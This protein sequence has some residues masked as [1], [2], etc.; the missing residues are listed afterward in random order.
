MNILRYIFQ[1]SLNVKKPLRTG[2]KMT[3]YQ[4]SFE[5]NIGLQSFVVNFVGANRQFAFLEISLVYDKSDQHKTTYDSYNT[6]VAVQKIKS[7]KIP[8]TSSTYPITN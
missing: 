7:L 1:L 8:N 4:Q 5:I 2:I 6:E 3:P